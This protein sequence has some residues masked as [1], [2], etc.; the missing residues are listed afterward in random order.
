MITY[1]ANHTWDGSSSWRSKVQQETSSSHQTELILPNGDTL[2]QHNS[3]SRMTHLQNSLCEY[4]RGLF[5]IGYVEICLMFDYFT[6]SIGSIRKSLNRYHCWC[7]TPWKQDRIHSLS[8]MSNI[9]GQKSSKYFKDSLKP[10][11]FDGR[12]RLLWYVQ[13]G[14]LRSEHPGYEIRWQP[15]HRQTLLLPL[16]FQSAMRRNETIY[17]SKVI[18]KNQE[19]SFPDMTNLD[20][21][22]E[23]D[24]LKQWKDIPHLLSLRQAADLQAL[25]LTDAHLQ[26][27][28]DPHVPH[29]LRLSVKGQALHTAQLFPVQNIYI[30]II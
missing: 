14:F 13:P 2:L 1:F 30:I 18:K 15:G 10:L 24:P 19:S 23:V 4:T 20:V 5:I 3:G 11:S 25:G 26:T 8:L 9:F 6:L 29:V 22:N 28:R 27:E 21:V 7:V 16:H 17:L 12:S